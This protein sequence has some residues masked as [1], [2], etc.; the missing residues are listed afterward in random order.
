MYSD[1]LGGEDWRRM[2]RR[3]AAARSAASG[4]SAP[5]GEKPAASGTAWRRVSAGAPD[6]A[7]GGAP[8]PGRGAAVGIETG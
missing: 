3:A 7:L 4:A 8:E 5:Q 1:E 2:S 6:G